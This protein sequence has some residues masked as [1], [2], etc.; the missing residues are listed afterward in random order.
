VAAQN[1]E[2]LAIDRVAIA[3][4]PVAAPCAKGIRGKNVGA[5]TKPVE[6][7]ED[8]CFELR[9]RPGA[10]VVLD[11]KQHATARRS[12]TI[13]DV[14]G[15]EDVPEVQPAG[16]RRSESRQ[17]WFNDSHSKELTQPRSNKRN[18]RSGRL[19]FFDISMRDTKTHK[20]TRYPVRPSSDSHNRELTPPDSNRR[21]GRK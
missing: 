3:L 18:G 4:T 21:N 20:S 16:R 6:V 5:V 11:T 19:S 17:Q 13:P 10:I 12:R 2:R 9:P 8:S 15:I 1:V 7:V 14:L